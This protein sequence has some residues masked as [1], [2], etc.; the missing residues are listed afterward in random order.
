MD[1]EWMRKHL[2]EKPPEG[3]E[4]WIVHEGRDD[5]MVDFMLFSAERVPVYPPRDFIETDEARKPLRHIWQARCS[6]TACGEESE[7]QY[8]NNGA[9][10]FLMYQ[11]E[12][13][14]LYFV[15]PLGS[16]EPQADDID[17]YG[18]DNSY[19]EIS[20]GDNMA[21]PWC[22]GYVDVIHRS[23]LKGGR[24][25]QVLGCA[26]QNIQGF[27]AVIYWLTANRI[28]DDGSHTVY[29]Y[30]RDAYVLTEHGGIQRYRHT[31]GSSGGF[32]GEYRLLEW[33]PTE[34]C[35]ESSTR[36]YHD[37]LSCNNTKFGA[38]VWKKTPYMGDCTGE[39]TALEDYIK[40]GG[41]YPVTYLKIWRRH[42]NV[43]NLVRNGWTALIEKNITEYVGM[44]PRHLKTDVHGVDFSK[45]KPHE[46]LKM[47]KPDFKALARNNDVW[48]PAKFEAWSEYRDVGGACN[49][50][51][52]S[53]YYR[54]FGKQGVGALM[55]LREDD[56]SI[57]FPK[58]EAYLKKQNLSCSNLGF[59]LDARNM[60][61]ALHPDIPLSQAELWPPRLM[62]VHDRLMALR[63]VNGDPVKNK[64]LK[65][66][67][68]KIVDCY[69]ELEWNDGDLR[70]ILPRGNDELV[71]EGAILHH[72]VGGYGPGH[73]AGK[74]VIFFVRKY[75]RPE[76]SFYT[77]DMNL[78]GSTPHEVQLHGYGNEFHT[79]PDGK[80]HHHRIPKKVRDFVDRWKQEI[81]MPWWV[82]QMTTEKKGKTA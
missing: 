6:C 23:K 22:G 19:I 61:D 52:F 35:N 24:T 7:T 25:K 66:G 36:A 62:A 47:S 72:C 63:R 68:L 69:G 17:D 26:V 81:L 20:E 71:R 44:N 49:A 34:T 51:Q 28:E 33:E 4:D 21:C 60:A 18:Y 43:E 82:G 80:R 10:G 30:P 70:I 29:T 56:D 38:L 53:K 45:K 75:R 48:D 64:E 73:V 42:R 27:T 32:S 78:S 79:G 14:C 37:W 40:Q 67:F 15:D 58:C 31:R 50:V 46:M 65:E 9:K 54:L 55:A 59:L 16:G 76:R 5:L 74:G 41:Q 1:R 77:L 39:K 11:G 13:G 57:D 12:D 2:P 8:V 3:Y